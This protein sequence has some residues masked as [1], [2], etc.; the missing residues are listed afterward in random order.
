[1]DVGDV[2]TLELSPQTAGRE[3]VDE[4]LARQPDPEPMDPDPVECL[5]LTE[6]DRARGQR[7]DLDLVATG[8]QPRRQV[9][10]LHLDAAQAREVAVGEHGDPHGPTL[11]CAGEWVSPCH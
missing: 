5:G 9:G 6:A 1:M 8:D 10:D 7:E 4:E 11:S 2:E 3:R